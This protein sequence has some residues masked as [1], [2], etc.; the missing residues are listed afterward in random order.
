MSVRGVELTELRPGDSDQLYAWI[1][2]RELVILNAPFA[3]VSRADHD[4]WFE[5]IRDRPDVAIFAIRLDGQLIGTCQ[6]NGIDR[7]AGTCSLQIRVGDRAEWGRGHGTKAIERLLDH[8]FGELGLRRV[9]L[10]VFATNP[11]A[12]RAYEKSGF[13]RVGLRPGAVEIEGEPV[14][15][16]EMVAERDG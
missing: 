13:E 7:D 10:E 4:Q 12:I 15:V 1:N 6:L 16:V 5:A 3:P 11:R 9:E 14:H 8:A 2:D